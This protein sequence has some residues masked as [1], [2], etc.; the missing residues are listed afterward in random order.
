M[1][2]APPRRRLSNH[3][4]IHAVRNLHLG[5]RGHVSR[6]HWLRD[7]AMQAELLN[8]QLDLRLPAAT[9][10]EL[11]A[12]YWRLGCRPGLPAPALAVLVPAP[13]AK[14]HADGRVSQRRQ[15]LAVPRPLSQDFL[16]RVQPAGMELV[17]A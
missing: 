9:I 16:V 13:A 2:S 10:A 6:K 12:R 5:I 1:A 14:R 15:Q 8:L 17:A 3:L 4:S 11:A 7:L